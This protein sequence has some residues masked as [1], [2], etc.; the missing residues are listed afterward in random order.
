MIKDIN[1]SLF[2]FVWGGSEKVKR[3]TIINSYE[4]G[5]L[6]M[7]H[8]PSFLDSLNGRGLKELQTKTQQTGRTFPF[9]KYKKLNLV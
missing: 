4:C 6:K 5:G 1:T 9:L 8:L 3:K 7:L 2:Q